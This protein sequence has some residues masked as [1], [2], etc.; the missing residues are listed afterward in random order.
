M[1]AVAHTCGVN[2]VSEQNE[3]TDHQKKFWPLAL[4]SLACGAFTFCPVARCEQRQ[5]QICLGS[6]NGYSLPYPGKLRT[7]PDT[8]EFR[9]IA[10]SRAA[11]KSRFN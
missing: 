6:I 4:G 1:G 3:S 9:P 11:P 2:S 7:P 10:S 8:F 5:N